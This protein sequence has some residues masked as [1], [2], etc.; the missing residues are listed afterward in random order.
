[1]GVMEKV[2]SDSASQMRYDSVNAQAIWAAPGSSL[3]VVA[4]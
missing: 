4:F 3:W 1:M 2:S